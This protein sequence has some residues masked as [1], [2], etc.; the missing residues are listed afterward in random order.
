VVTYGRSGSTLV[1]G[2]LNTLPRVLVR[3]ENSFYVLPLYRAMAQTMAFRELHYNH[4]PRQVSSAFYGLRAVRRARFVSATRRLM[5]ENLLGP[6]DRSAVDVL[7]FKEV[8]WHEVSAEE[9]ADFFDFFDETF[10]GARYVLNTRK[11]EDV[12]A[13]GF[14]QKH[15]SDEVYA[16]IKRVEEI[17]QHLRQTRPD[18]VLD[19]RYELLTGE[20]REVSDAQLRSLAEFVVGSGDEDLMDQLRETLRTGHGPYAFGASHGRRKSPDQG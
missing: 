4:R 16:A 14:W 7:G 2:L 13:S 17:Q 6:I 10:P 5:T 9:T 1:Q 15:D 19:I 18:R 20:D 11:H 3:G 8:L 12:A